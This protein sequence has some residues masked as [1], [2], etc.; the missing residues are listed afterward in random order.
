MNLLWDIKSLNFIKTEGDFW[1]QHTPYLEQLIDILE[2]N[3][4]L[5][6][7]KYI[8]VADKYYPLENSADI[9][10]R[11]KNVKNKSFSFELVEDKNDT[12]KISIYNTKEM[13]NIQFVIKN[14]PLPPEFFSQAKKTT[15]EIYKCFKD[16]AVMGSKVNIP[17]LEFDFP[18]FRPTRKI[19][20]GSYKSIIDFIDTRFYE[21]PYF[22][23]LKMENMDKL[24]TE[25]LP[26]GCIREKIDDLYVFTWINNF[27]EENIRTSL[28]QREEWLY[29]VLNPPLD[30]DFN[31]FGD[32]EGVTILPDK[33]EVNTFFTAFND[34]IHIGYKAITLTQDNDFDPEIRK[35]LAH[36]MKEGKLENGDKIERIYL[37]V[38]ARKH[39]IAIQKKAKEIGITNIYYTDNTNS[40]W[41]ICPEGNWRN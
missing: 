37:I 35:Q 1:W 26:E 8:N 9:V 27:E 21:H 3:N 23:H 25:P 29:K 2:R 31:E 6:A 13:I 38:P 33:H 30:A 24:Y 40:L 17:F 7:I 16:I 36:Y 5:A 18:R 39:A 28:M 22:R 11:V 4:H 19:N 32:R 15:I 20:F 34:L 12:G 41:D 10:S 14:K